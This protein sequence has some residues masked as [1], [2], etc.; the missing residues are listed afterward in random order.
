MVTTF[1]QKVKAAIGSILVLAIFA[2]IGAYL[3]HR[4]MAKKLER[5]RQLK[6]E[7]FTALNLAQGDVSLLHR[8]N[9]KIV[10]RAKTLKARL[11]TLKN[12][13]DKEAIEA[14]TGKVKRLETLINTKFKVQSSFK[15]KIRDTTIY[16]HDT[17]FKNNRG[18]Y[19][20]D[21][22]LILDCSIGDSAACK[23]SY[24]D[25]ITTVIH[26]QPAGKWWQFWKW[27]KKNIY[28]D[29]IFDNPNARATYVRSILVNDK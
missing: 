27:G 18:F 1:K 29:V 26:Q 4:H 13:P 5:E 24:Q 14:L 10:A 8:E 9:N 20:A 19:Y 15:T 22:H 21:K 11:E 23:Y 2:A 3:E 7:A 16:L 17:V 6:K 12:L 25:S 28:T